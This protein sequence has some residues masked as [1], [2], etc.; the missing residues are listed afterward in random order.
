[1]ETIVVGFDG[2]ETS[3]VALD[4]VAERAAHRPLRIEIVTIGGTML[5]DGS[6]APLRDAARRITDR[7]PETE[8]DAHRFAGRMPDALLERARGADLLVVGSH[9]GRPVWS[10]L[11][12]WM[13][14]RVASRSP[15][16][17]IVVPDDWE[18]TSGK[19]IVGMDDDDSSLAALDFAA[20]EAAASDV[21]LVLVHTWKMPV[22]Q[23]E[24]SV[25]LLA[26]PI[27]A[28]AGH[29]R[30]LREATQRAQGAHPGLVVEHVLEQGNPVSALLH[31][32]R[33][34]S[35]LVIGTHHR[36]RF[37]GALLGSIGQDLLTQCRI[38]VCVVPGDPTS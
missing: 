31:A 24:G 10:A 2:S 32:A 13:P 19:V 1:V 11:A 4:W 35:M 33:G 7:S 20:R 38:P 28:R 9:R 16:P 25:A 12:R 17:A 21:P 22:P 14:L 5:Q 36:G 27:E 30:I 37:A 3:V 18:A 6:D 34:A 29:R 15:S 26:S 8:V 23:M